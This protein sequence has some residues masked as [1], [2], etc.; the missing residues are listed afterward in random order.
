MFSKQGLPPFFLFFSEFAQTSQSYPIL[1]CT[2]HL[3]K[4]PASTGEKKREKVLLCDV[5]CICMALFVLHFDLV[6]VNIAFIK[7]TALFAFKK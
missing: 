1:V 5:C 3:N 6:K 2:G 4:S 7:S